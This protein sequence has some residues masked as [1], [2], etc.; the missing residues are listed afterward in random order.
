VTTT[1]DAQG[2][3]R[4]SGSAGD[5]SPARQTVKRQHTPLFAAALA[6]AIVGPLVV[7][8]PLSTVAFG[9]LVLGCPL[10]M[11]F[12]HGGHGAGDGRPGAAAEEPRRAP[13]GRPAVTASSVR[14]HLH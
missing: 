11:L 14:R 3:A 7:G 10:I 6:I 8:V 9:L 2:S 1:G 12:V 13:P 4:P 5:A